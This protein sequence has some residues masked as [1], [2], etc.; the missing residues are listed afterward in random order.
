MSNL[1]AS[2]RYDVGEG[3]E[4]GLDFQVRVTD[5]RLMSVTSGLDGELGISLGSMGWLE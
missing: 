2:I 4:T 5:V 1:N 3:P